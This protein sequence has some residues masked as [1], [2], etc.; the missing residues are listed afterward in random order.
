MRKI[1]YKLIVFMVLVMVLSSIVEIILWRI[2]DSKSVSELTNGKYYIADSIG[3]QPGEPEKFIFA[4]V[5]SK[6]HKAIGDWIKKYKI[7][8]NK[9]GCIKLIVNG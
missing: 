1:I 3:S 9:R 6:T 5:D 4:L 7:D 8:I 2:D